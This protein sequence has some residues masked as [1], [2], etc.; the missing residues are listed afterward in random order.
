MTGEKSAAIIRQRFVWGEMRSAKNT[1]GQNQLG[2]Q[3]GRAIGE[4]V[5]EIDPTPARNQWEQKA[6]FIDPI[7]LMILSLTMR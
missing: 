5:K 1:G 4:I 6:S 2:C 7:R 3:P